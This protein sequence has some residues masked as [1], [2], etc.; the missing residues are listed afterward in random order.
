MEQKIQ[1]MLVPKDSPYWNWWFMSEYFHYD[2]KM[3]LVK[4]MYIRI[5]EE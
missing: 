1:K 5:F 4:Y 2:Y 3:K